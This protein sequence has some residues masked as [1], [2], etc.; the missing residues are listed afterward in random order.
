MNI[1]LVPFAGRPVRSLACSVFEFT[2]S[3]YAGGLRIAKHAHAEPYIGITVSGEWEQE[4]GDRW[5]RGG[6]WTVT[7]HPA[8]EIHS[9]RF[10]ANGAKI[11]NIN[12][13]L[14][15]LQ[16]LLGL[17]LN[18]K[19]SVGLNEGKAVWLARMIYQE[20]GRSDEVTTLILNGLAL[21]LLAELLGSCYFQQDLAVP[22]WLL[23][24]KEMI[25]AHFAEPLR[26]QSIAATVGVHPV[27]LAREF[28]RRFHATI[29]EDIRD[30]RIARACQ[31]LTGSSLPLAQI[32]LEVGFSDQ[33]SFTT[34]FHRRTGL[35]PSEF[36]RL[37]RSC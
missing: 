28:H 11:L 36:R 18:V 4:Y 5:R 17:S 12:I 9:N 32:A 16:Q 25:E 6:P 30:L 35:T 37:H 19:H 31:L 26:L 7:L 8:G 24:A 2:E 3:L 21:Q 14:S 33:P 27:H 22:E 34:A 29:G 13:A 23:R 20:F 15:R 10:Y 1:H